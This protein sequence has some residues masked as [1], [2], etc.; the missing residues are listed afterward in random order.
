MGKHNHLGLLA[1]AKEFCK[2][3]ERLNTGPQR[4][5]GPLP[6][7]FLFMHAVECGLKSYLYYR[8]V[9]EDS[10]RKLGHDLEA[11]WQKAMDLGICQLSSECKELRECIHLINP[12]YKGTQLDYLYPGPKRLPVIEDVHRL[13][14]N[15]IIDLDNAYS[16]GELP[17]PGP[18][19]SGGCATS[20]SSL[21]QQR[22]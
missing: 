16:L 7:N 4:L 19:C 21:G 20:D 11:A 13:C 9:D 17:E 15:L 6:V 3:A 14:K 1:V 10:L 12:I 22:G 2:S 8:G 18:E 5:D